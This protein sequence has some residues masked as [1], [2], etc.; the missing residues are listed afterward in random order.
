MHSQHLQDF[1]EALGAVTNFMGVNLQQALYREGINLL[2]SEFQR[3]LLRHLRTFLG[4]E[5][6]EAPNQGGGPTDIQYRTVTIELKV[7]RQIADR[8][9]MIGK[10]VPQTT[11]YSSARG[12]QLG[13]LCILDLTEKCEPPANPKNNVTLE[14]PE[15]HGF[16]GE[17]APFPCRIAAVVIDGN[18]RLPSSYSR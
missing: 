6:Q 4:E 10:Y 18:L 7:E 15:V 12:A 3:D 2:E 14:A 16:K 9:K 17:A 13:I 8:R 11:Q 1:I 5:V